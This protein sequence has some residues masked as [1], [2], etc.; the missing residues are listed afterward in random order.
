MRKTERKGEK[1][2]KYE[3]R[4]KEKG[5]KKGTLKFHDISSI[6]VFSGDTSLGS[7]SWNFVITHFHIQ[8]KEK[9]LYIEF[10]CS[11]NIVAFYFPPIAKFFFQFNIF[12]VYM[13]LLI[14]CEESLKQSIIVI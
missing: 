2:G 3:E 1:K 9:F 10:M 4:K 7:V 6:G 8:Y 14:F 12:Y 13:N 5:R 11:L